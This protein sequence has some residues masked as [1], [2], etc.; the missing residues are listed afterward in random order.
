MAVCT[1]NAYLAIASLRVVREYSDRP[2]S[3]QSV[4]RILEAGRAT[5]SSKNA[6]R[7]RFYVVT[8]RA[9]L[10]RLADTVFAPGN[11]QGAQVAIAI[12]NMGKGDF[13]IG[14]V[15]QN[16]MLAAWS[17]GIGSAPNSVRDAEAI[18]SLIPVQEGETVRTVLSLGYPQHPRQI[19]EDDVDGILQRIDRKPLDELVVRVN[20]K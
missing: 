10:S 17:E 6:Q 1:V 16:M 4:N 20:G 13:D 18:R 14:R 5:G 15:A 19:R 2:I 12:G 9:S 11:I 7:W 3:G 8:D